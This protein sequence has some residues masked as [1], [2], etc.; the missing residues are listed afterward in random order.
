MSE[1]KKKKYRYA[2]VAKKGW[3]YPNADKREGDTKPDYR[4]K[5]VGLEVENLKPLVDEEGHVSLSI[6][7]WV[8]EDQRGDKRIGLSVQSM[9]ES[10][11]PAVG[12]GEAPF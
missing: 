9:E 2:K 7:G 1:E 10:D 12:E 5:I 6:S 4:G 8:E 3:L 11:A